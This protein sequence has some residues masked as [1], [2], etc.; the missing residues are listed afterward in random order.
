MIVSPAAK[1]VASAAMVE[2][3]NAAGT[4]IHTWRGTSS[5]STNSASECVP[6]IPSLASLSTAPASTS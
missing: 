1:R 2:S 3:T 4:M 5:F 6:C